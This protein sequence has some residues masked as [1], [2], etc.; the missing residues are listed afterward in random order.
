[1]R[2]TLPGIGAGGWGI[3]RRSSSRSSIPDPRSPALP[4]G[5]WLVAAVVSA[6]VAL[7]VATG[8]PAAALAPLGG[9]AIGALVLRAPLRWPLVAVMAAVMLAD[10]V[11]QPASADN[12]V[13][14]APATRILQLLLI[15]NLN[16][17]TG[18]G[19][20]KIAGME[21]ALIACALLAG[22]RSLAGA[23]V[24]R[25]GADRSSGLALAVSAGAFVAVL[26]MEG[27]GVLRGG[28]D[29]R[30]SLWQFRQLL[31]LPVLTAL[32]LYALRGVRDGRALLVTVTG[33]A[34]LKVAIGLSFFLRVRFA[35]GAKPQSVTSHADTVLFVV[36]MALWAGVAVDRF[37]WQRVLAAAGAWA[38]M[39]VGIVVNNRRTAFVSLAATLFVL[40]TVQPPRRRQLVV[41]AAICCLPFGAAYLAVGSR[42]QTGIFAPA[43]SILSVTQQKDASSA[44]RDIENYNLIQTL[45]PNRLL[46]TGWGHEYNELV[47][48][49]DIAS[50]FP[51]YRYVAHNSVLWLWSI[52]GFVGFTLLWLQVAVGVFLAA[53]SH[54]FARTTAERATAYGALAVFTAY[55]IQAWADMGVMSWTTVS[56]MACALALSAKLAV[57]TGAMPARLPLLAR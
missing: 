10:I 51:Q 12:P 56:L 53:R 4:R 38:W 8:Q 54:R 19:A 26:A 20:L 55:V 42:V 35:G 1:M 39:L 7:L 34:A 3:A 43:A 31:F 29:V 25:A 16:T 50:I 57:R 45:K 36:V 48:A 14:F 52:G 5:T 13:A 2:T 17:L 27:W 40:F 18:V 37:A 28:A 49:Y 46:G 9:V 22:V 33:V 6:S 44:T 21:L 32:L 23:R 47:K 15:E 41:R 30:Q 11:A 24:D